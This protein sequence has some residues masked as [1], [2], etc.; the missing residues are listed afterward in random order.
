VDGGVVGMK[1]LDDID[2]QVADEIEAAVQFAEASPEPA[3]EDLYRDV[4]AE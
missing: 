1:S 3:M 2:R 4:Y